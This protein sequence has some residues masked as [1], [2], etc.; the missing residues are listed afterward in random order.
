MSQQDIPGVS[1]LSLNISWLSLHLP[2]YRLSDGLPTN[3]QTGLSPESDPRT[4][5]AD[6]VF[7][8]NDA[9]DSNAVKVDGQCSPDAEFSM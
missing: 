8:L 1:A 2:L 9:R 7:R 4:E 5:E 6:S 3:T